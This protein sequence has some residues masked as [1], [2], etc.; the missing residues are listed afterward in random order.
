[1][2]N[3]EDFKAYLEGSHYSNVRKFP[4]GWAGITKMMFTWALCT[5]LDMTGY[6]R[7]YCYTSE[8]RAVAELGK[9]QSLDD[10]PEGWE[11]RLPEPF[12]FTI[13]GFQG[14]HSHV[15][16]CMTER[17]IIEQANRYS[18]AHCLKVADRPPNATTVREALTL[19]NTDGGVLE[20][21]NVAEEAPAFIARAEFLGLGQ[22]AKA[23]AARVR[24]R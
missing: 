8:S 3:D 9:M 2:M 10:V 17:E 6:G 4:Q 14:R 24:I 23:L 12:Y 16:Q 13:V 19:L 5:E 7:R 18:I 11:R 15:G 21:F 1:M 22:E 20:A